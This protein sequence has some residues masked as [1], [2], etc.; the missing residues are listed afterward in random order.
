MR[1]YKSNYIE[2]QARTNTHNTHTKDAHAHTHTYT[3][4]LCHVLTYFLDAFHQQFAFTIESMNLILQL[5]FRICLYACAFGYI[6]IF[7]PPCQMCVYARMCMQLAMPAVVSKALAILVCV[8]A[9]MHT[10]M[11]ECMNMHPHTRLHRSS[12][13][14]F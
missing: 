12:G 8:C 7:T 11:L 4:L 1:T 3:N 5:C 13:F 10:C 9:H 2:M 14:E 6:C